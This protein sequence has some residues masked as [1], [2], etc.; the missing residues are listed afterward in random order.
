[1]IMKDT[2]N[3]YSAVTIVSATMFGEGEKNQDR[4]RWYGPGQIACICDGVTTSPYAERSAELV[5]QFAPVLFDNNKENNFQIICDLLIA[6]RKEYQQDKIV[7]PDGTAPTI[8]AILRKVIQEKRKTSFQ[9]TMVAVKIKCD[10]KTVATHIFK[11]GD[12]A[13]FAFSHEG[14]LL[15]SS[16]TNS[17]VNNRAT[18]NKRNNH[19]SLLDGISFGPGH[20]I[21][22]RVEGLLCHNKALAQQT[23]IGDTHLKNWIVCTPIENCGKVTYQID[24]AQQPLPGLSLKPVDRLLVPRYLYG[25][26]ITSKGHRYYVLD[27]S[28]TVRVLSI[29]GELTSHSKIDQRGSTTLV[30]PDHFYKGYVE[31]YQDRFPKGTHFVLCS[32]GFYNCFSD[33]KYLW[34]WLKNHA[35]TLS[36]KDERQSLLRQLHSQLDAKSGDDDISFVWAYPRTTNVIGTYQL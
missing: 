1:M 21:L 16:L 13:F 20:Q 26:K 22:V 27:Y 30:L 5:T 36:H 14:E 23:N 7:I 24:N 28:S 32:D 34:Q 8:Q 18:Q 6:L 29:E 19:Y 10:E 35:K 2:I 31:S 15:S 33:A 3:T 4:A 25:T 11:C 9:T 17:P 12:S